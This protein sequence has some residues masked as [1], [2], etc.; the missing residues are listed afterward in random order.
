MRISDWS[1]DVCSSDLRAIRTILALAGAED[2]RAGQSRPATHRMDDGRA[3]EVGEARFGEPAAA[4]GPGALDRV[5]EPG[6]DH[7]EDHERPELDALG[8]GARDDRD[9]KSVV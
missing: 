6:Q 3:G 7:G 4:P 9:R 5:D 1:S 2:Q 8:K